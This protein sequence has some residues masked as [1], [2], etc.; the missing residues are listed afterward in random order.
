MEL[1]D[2]VAGFDFNIDDWIDFL[3]VYKPYLKQ[4]YEKMFND[5]TWAISILNQT[6]ELKQ[7][8]I[9]LNLTISPEEVKEVW[10][11]D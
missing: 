7:E 5:Y 8:R 3:D 1:P 4:D 9:K 2:K 6:Y 11:E 10:N